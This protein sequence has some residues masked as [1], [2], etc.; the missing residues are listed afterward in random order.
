[1]KIRYTEKIFEI[2]R[3]YPGFLRKQP[4]FKILVMPLFD[5]QATMPASFV[6]TG[7][8]KADRIQC[9]FHVFEIK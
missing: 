3:E 8:D 9:L 5:F 2:D 4:P 7:F 1:V 6:G